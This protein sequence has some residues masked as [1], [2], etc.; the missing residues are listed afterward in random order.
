MGDEHPTW[1]SPTFD[2]RGDVDPTAIEIV[3][4]NDQVAE[5][6]ADAQFDATDPRFRC[7]GFA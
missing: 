4:L 2:A 3:P 1:V 7:R 5:M 6:D